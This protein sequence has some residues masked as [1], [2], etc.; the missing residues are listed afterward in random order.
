MVR[1]LHTPGNGNGLPGVELKMFCIPALLS[2]RLMGA[3]AAA[4]SWMC[5]ARRKRR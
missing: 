3:W 5:R 1:I 4:I 2:C